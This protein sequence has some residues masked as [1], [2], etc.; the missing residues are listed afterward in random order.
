[1]VYKKNDFTNTQTIL[2]TF[3]YFVALNVFD[4]Q[5]ME[6]MAVTSIN[7]I[8]HIISYKPWSRVLY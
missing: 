5:Q 3:G 6:H 4:I 1:M 2:P 7:Q 8:Y